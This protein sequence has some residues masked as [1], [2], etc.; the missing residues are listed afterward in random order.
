MS[1]GF[2]MDR[3]LVF[4]TSFWTNPFNP[5]GKSIFMYICIYISADI[6]MH[7]YICLLFR[8][9]G[10]CISSSKLTWFIFFNYTFQLLW[11]SSTRGQNAPPTLPTVYRRV[12]YS[13]VRF[14]MNGIWFLCTFFTN[15]LSTAAVLLPKCAHA[16][17][18]SPTRVLLF[19]LPR[20]LRATCSVI[21]VAWYLHVIKSTLVI[22]VL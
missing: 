5:A 15:H 10:G 20:S 21:I 17:S 6:H 8:G 1:D 13:V 3:Y 22:P 2:Q 16:L 7:R 9:G 12:I 18:F 19:P 4:P 14:Y 11:G